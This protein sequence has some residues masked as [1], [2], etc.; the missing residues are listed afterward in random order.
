MRPSLKL[1][2]FALL[3]ADSI[4]AVAAATATTTTVTTIVRIYHV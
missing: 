3:V 1:L 2:L 4:G